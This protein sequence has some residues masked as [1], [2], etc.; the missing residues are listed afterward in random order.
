MKK[1]KIL[2]LEKFFMLAV[3]AFLP[4]IAF[5]Q[6]GGVVEIL[7]S[8]SAI[9]S[10]VLPVLVSFGVVYFIWGVVQYVIADG[11]EAK[12]AGKD[13]IIFGIIGLAI[14]ISVWGLVYLLTTTFGLGQGGQGAPTNLSNLTPT[15]TTGSTCAM[16]G[17]FQDLLNYATCII[18]KSVVPLIF[19][20][21]IVMFIWG[22][23]NFFILNAD[24]EA[25]R[26][27]GKQFMI[28]G[29]IALAVMVSVWGLVRILGNTF[30]INYG[31]PQVKSK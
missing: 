5:A 24:E 20:L 16:G 15:V 27:Q 4:F 31:V 1:Q 7:S 23:V 13:R 9:L 17:K 19:A 28:W 18:G 8:I 30:N 21:A 25:K 3:F 22:S 14:I 6:T 10:A 12:K 26:S 29:V 2:L 11:E